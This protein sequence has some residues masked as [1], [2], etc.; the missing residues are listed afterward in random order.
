MN[1][2]G[3]CLRVT[4]DSPQL[5]IDKAKQTAIRADPNPSLTVFANRAYETVRQPFLDPELTKDSVAIA[6]Q[7]ATFHANPQRTVPRNRQA[8]NI[9]LSKRAC[10][11]TV[12]GLE[13]FPVETNQSPGC[14]N[15]KISVRG[16][17]KGLYDL[18]W[19]SVL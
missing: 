17:G 2:N 15:P 4:V 7:S 3:R 1:G 9:V 16:L 14:A 19:Q 8:K 18:L 12:E 11:F 6:N 10:I 13:S 5:L